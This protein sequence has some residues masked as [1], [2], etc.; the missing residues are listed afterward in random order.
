MRGEMAKKEKRS[1]RE[2]GFIA[3]LRLLR[4]LRR[5]GSRKGAC[6]WA[7]IT[8]AELADCLEGNPRL[9][10]ALERAEMRSLAKDERRLDSSV[11][12]GDRVAL[13]FR[14]RNIHGYGEA[15]AREGAEVTIGQR[16]REF[17]E[18]EAEIRSLGKRG[19]QELAGA[20][21]EAVPV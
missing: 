5:G 11:R 7:G 10:A 17:G 6:G 19:R 14:M 20:Y 3:L 8:H 16:S 4:H 15:R 1:G 12:K 13:L 18:V 21:R 2:F 9:V